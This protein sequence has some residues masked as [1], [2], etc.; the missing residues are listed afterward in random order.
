[1]SFTSSRIYLSINNPFIDYFL[2]FYNVLDWASFFR[3]VRGY[4]AIIPRLSE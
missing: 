4:G 3:K 1:M 2:W